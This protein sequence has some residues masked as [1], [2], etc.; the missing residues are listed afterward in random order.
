MEW[1]ASISALLHAGP[2]VGT[3]FLGGGIQIFCSGGNQFEGVQI[4]RDIP[5]VYPIGHS[6]QTSSQINET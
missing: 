4:K 5:K 2:L 3:N 1:P 6:K